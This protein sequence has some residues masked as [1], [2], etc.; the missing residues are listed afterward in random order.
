MRIARDTANLPNW[1]K[2]SASSYGT[3]GLIVLA[4]LMFQQ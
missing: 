1:M 3:A 2:Q 4:A